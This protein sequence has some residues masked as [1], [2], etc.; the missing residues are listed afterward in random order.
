MGQMRSHRPTLTQQKTDNHQS[1]KKKKGKCTNQH[2]TVT[3]AAFDDAMDW[4]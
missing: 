2:T 3:R 4:T 1:R